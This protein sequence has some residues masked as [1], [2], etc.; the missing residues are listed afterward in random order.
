MSDEK[1]SKG[2][3][4]RSLSPSLPGKVLAYARNLGGKLGRSSSKAIARIFDGY[5]IH[6]TKRPGKAVFVTIM[7]PEGWMIYGAE[8][9]AS[10]MDNVP[11]GFIDAGIFPISYTTTIGDIL[12]AN[13]DSN[14]ITAGDIDLAK[15]KKLD[16]SDIFTTA[17][18]VTSDAT[19][20]LSTSPLV[21]HGSHVTWCWEIQQENG[22][23]LFG[24]LTY[25]IVTAY[26]GQSRK[27]SVIDGAETVTVD[28][29]SNRLA[30]II[31]DNEFGTML[32]NE[33]IKRNVGVQTL[34]EPNCAL[35][36]INN[37][38]S[39]AFVLKD[40]VTSKRTSMLIVS[41]VV[42]TS[43][44]TGGNWGDC[45]EGERAEHYDE[46]GA[47]RVSSLCGHALLLLDL[48]A[49]E[50][51]LADPAGAVAAADGRVMAAHTALLTD[52]PDLTDAGQQFDAYSAPS[53]MGA[54][55]NSLII[56]DCYRP[57]IILQM[58]SAVLEPL[59]DTAPET[60]R[61]LHPGERPDYYG[62]TKVISAITF[63]YYHSDPESIGDEFPTSPYYDGGGAFQA[64]PDSGSLYKTVCTRLFTHELSE[65][66]T[67]FSVSSVEVAKVT[68]YLG[69]VNVRA[70]A[71]PAYVYHAWP[72]IFTDT[73]IDTPVSTASS[74]TFDMHYLYCASGSAIPM[75]AITLDEWLPA[76]EYGVACI[77]Q[78]ATGTDTFKLAYPDGEITSFDL[79][80]YH[81]PRPVMRGALFSNYFGEFPTFQYDTSTPF[82]ETMTVNG[83][84][85]GTNPSS[86]RF[87]ELSV[88]TI[89]Q[90]I[91][92]H[93]GNG[94]IAILATNGTD[95][96]V[97]LD[98]SVIKCYESTGQLT[99]EA[100]AVVFAGLPLESSNWISMTCLSA[101]IGDSEGNVSVP[102][103][104]LC[105][106]QRP[107][108]LFDNGR[109]NES[110]KYPE[111]QREVIDNVHR[112]D[113]RSEQRISRDGG[114]TWEVFLTGMPGDGFYLGN[115]IKPASFK[116]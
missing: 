42:S 48:K 6:A 51:D 104:L 92:A 52:Y 77:G 80:S 17:T 82:A 64:R 84:A 27:S 9:L 11:A 46:Y 45:I 110:R 97:V 55:E 85:V 70:V 5:I 40:P 103:V 1:K 19:S 88:A 13:A 116:G 21:P 59:S 79:G 101:E 67:A 3:I 62:A 20:T 34:Y 86:G 30:V 95:T 26:S 54:T 24:P 38:P 87:T 112:Y 96:D 16:F 37:V 113:N 76:Q 105:S 94:K 28:P 12:P 75:V 111:T 98:W 29:L 14:P 44:P 72:Y 90:K 53:D 49:T 39:Q 22:L 15:V 35:S 107:R 57:N 83:S 61:D 31:S 106:L 33:S 36:G 60:P 91:H 68:Q 50:E 4:V 7:S 89:N 32:G 115:S 58:S 109:P 99:G 43:L 56:P 78:Q 74:T 108:T 18:Q 10:R 73:G 47:W 93:I 102:A 2:V 65:D 8:V 71:D 100:S 63:E 41:P 69:W 66:G 81:P 25:Q 23:G 114:E